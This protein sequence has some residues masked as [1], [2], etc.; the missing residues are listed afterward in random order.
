[1]DQFC[2]GYFSTMIKVLTL[3]NNIKEYLENDNIPHTAE[4]FLYETIEKYN[5]NVKRF[6]TSYSLIRADRLEK[7]V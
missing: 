2:F 1:M 5:L 3:F 4:S 6:I 7:I